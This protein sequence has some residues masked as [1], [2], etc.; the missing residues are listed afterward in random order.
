TGRHH[1]PGYPRSES[2]GVVVRHAGPRAG[3]TGAHAG[4]DQHGADIGDRRAA[5][6]GDRG[7]VF[8]RTRGPRDR[9]SSTPAMNTPSRY[10]ATAGPALQA[11]DHAPIRPI[12]TRIVI[13]LAGFGALAIATCV[14]APLVGSTHISLARA[15]DRSIPFADNVDAQIFFVAR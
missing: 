14:L 12:R 1:G 11:L 15:F 7:C 6:R 9:R 2:G 4:T 5:L 3:W 8:P 10:A 13:T